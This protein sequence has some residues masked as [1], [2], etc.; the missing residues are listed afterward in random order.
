MARPPLPTRGQL[1]PCMGDGVWK[2]R[3]VN[4]L[5]T[6]MGKLVCSSE[7]SGLVFTGLSMYTVWY[8]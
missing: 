4:S 6:E 1:Q 2:P 5:Q 8:W 3:R 7:L